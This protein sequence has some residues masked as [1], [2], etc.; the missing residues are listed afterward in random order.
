[1]IPVAFRLLSVGSAT[2][3]LVELLHEAVN[4]L[5]GELWECIPYWLPSVVRR[6]KEDD[7]AY[8]QTR[9]VLSSQPSPGAKASF[10]KILARARGVSADLRAWCREE[11][12]RA[13]G[14]L[15]AEVGLDLIAGRKRLVMQS[16][17]DLMS[18]RD[19]LYDAV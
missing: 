15:I 9:N 5:Q 13:E 8:E 10:P 14:D 12:Q 3:H 11:C 7:T 18:A 6:L 4:R 17:F 19:V 2:E 1:M 16:L